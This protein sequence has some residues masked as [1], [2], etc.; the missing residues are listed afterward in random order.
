MYNDNAIVV[1]KIV[2]ENKHLKF[3]VFIFYLSSIIWIIRGVK[4][5]LECKN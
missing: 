1:K 4:F 2:I 3:A 5:D